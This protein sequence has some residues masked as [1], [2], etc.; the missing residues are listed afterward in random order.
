MTSGTRWSRLGGWSHRSEDAAPTIP[1]REKRVAKL[2]FDLA[3]YTPDLHFT[4]MLAVESAVG[5]VSFLTGMQGRLA[6]ACRHHNR[7]AAKC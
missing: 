4:A 5:E 2:I 7:P 6:I 1:T 3:G